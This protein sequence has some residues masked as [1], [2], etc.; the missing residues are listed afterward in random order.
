[1]IPPIVREVEQ[2]GSQLPTYVKRLR[3]LGRKQRAVPRAQRQVR[4]HPAALAGGRAAAGALGDAAGAVKAITVGL[5]NNLVEAIIVLTLAFFLLLD[6]GRAS[7]SARPPRLRRAASAN[8]CAASARGSPASCA[9]TSRSTSLLAVAAGLFTWLVL[10]LLGVDLAVPLAVL[11]GVLDLVPL[12]GFTIGG[13]LVAVVAA[14]HDFPTALIVWA[15]AVRRLP[16]APGPGD[17]AALLPAARC[18]STRGRD[19]RRARGRPARRHPRRP[20]GDPGRRLAR[21]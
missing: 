19:R 21:R 7:S 15:V 8:A 17:P 3:E 1:M 10:E 9:P 11:V 16:A 18:R 6:G 20:A 4:H 14:L 5:L 13:L 12:I 2:L